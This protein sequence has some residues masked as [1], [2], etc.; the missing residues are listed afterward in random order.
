[1]LDRLCKN[2]HGPI[3][4]VRAPQARHCSAECRIAWSRPSN[5]CVDCGVETT[6]ERCRGCQ[7][8]YAQGCS[9]QSPNH[10]RYSDEEMLESLRA[11]AAKNGGEVPSFLRCQWAKVTPSPRAIAQRFGSWNHA[12]RLAGVPTN[13]RRLQA[14]SQQGEHGGHRRNRSMVTGGRRHSKSYPVLLSVDR[15]VA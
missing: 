8:R 5:T 9:R 11:L 12:L 2:C 14:T 4:G 6:G 1:M 10:R 7:L 3:P 13:D 15:Y